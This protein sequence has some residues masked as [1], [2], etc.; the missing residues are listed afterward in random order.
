M[1][2]DI[3]RNLLEYVAEHTFVVG[4]VVQLLLRLCAMVAVEIAQWHVCLT[5]V[6]TDVLDPKQVMA[7]GLDVLLVAHHIVVY[8]AVCS[9]QTEKAVAVAE[10]YATI[11][12]QTVQYQQTDLVV[13]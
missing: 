2:Q 10:L 3:V 9:V 1:R 5:Q 13:M 11:E 6:I 4:Q 7:A 12:A 8:D